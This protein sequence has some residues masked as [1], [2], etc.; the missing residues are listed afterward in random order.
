MLSFI[1]LKIYSKFEKKTLFIILMLIIFVM[2]IIYAQATVN[3]GSASRHHMPTI[4]I[5]ILLYFFPSKKI[6]KIK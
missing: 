1:L 2:E 6:N 3:W 5:L 4:G